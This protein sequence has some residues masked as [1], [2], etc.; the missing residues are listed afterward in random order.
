MSGGSEPNDAVH[1]VANDRLTRLNAKIVQR[2]RQGPYGKRVLIGLRRD[3][4]VPFPAPVPKVPIRL[5]SLRPEDLPTLFPPTDGVAAEREHADVTWRLRMVEQGS[6]RSRC[7]VAVDDTAGRPCHIQWLTMGYSDAIRAAAALP[8]LSLDEALLENAYTPSGY[9]G[10]GIM[11]AVTARIAD[12]AASSGLRYVVALV[13]QRNVT[14]LRGGRQAGLA[15]W[16][17][18]TLR[19]LGFGL[20]RWGR[21]AP[22]PALP[23]PPESAIDATG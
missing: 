2:L 17:I 7:F 3:L 12:H 1:T 13:D 8:A 11:S 10:M 16:R 21:F 4:S 14:S 6:L 15:P 19:Q 23:M 20:F 5:R 9:R 18:A 22:T